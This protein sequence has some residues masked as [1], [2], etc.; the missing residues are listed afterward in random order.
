MAKP[1][2]HCEMNQNKQYA[3]TYTPTWRDGKKYNIRE[4]LG[5]V[6]LISTE[7]LLTKVFLV[8]RAIFLARFECFKLKKY[9]K[10]RH[11]HKF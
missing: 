2:I 6:I 3:S 11:L 1:F 9:R 10:I 7:N 8:P 4:N 5:R